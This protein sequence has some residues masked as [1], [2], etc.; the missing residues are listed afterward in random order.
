MQY[1]TT[2]ASEIETHL[3]DQLPPW[4]RTIVAAGDSQEVG[5]RIAGYAVAF[6]RSLVNAVVVFVLAFILTLYLL[7]EGRRTYAWIL[8]FVPPRFRDRAERTARETRSVVSAYVAGNVATSLFATI[9]VLVV[10]SVL[11]VP[12]ALL[13]AVLAGICD[14]IP[15]LGF[16]LSV[17]PAALLA[18]T[19]SARVA[20]IAILCYV[21]YHLIEN[22]YIAP[23]V[24]GA[25]LKLSN[26]AVILAFAV[27]AEVAG[28]V[29]ALIALPIAAVYPAIERIWLR[30][31]VGSDTV[32]QHQ[33]IERRAG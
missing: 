25:R 19:V 10:L 23:K 6:A 11:K 20:M 15:V 18:A 14:F 16:I 27:G 2:H 4:A 17:A 12:A 7:I 31:T 22:Y 1:L 8:A 33:T 9:F 13:L 30:D 3:V 21:A 28:V 29:G 24:Y 32:Q 5:S 26:V